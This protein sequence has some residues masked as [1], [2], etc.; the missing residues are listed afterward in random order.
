M[1][2]YKDETGLYIETEYFEKI[3][4]SFELKNLIKENKKRLWFYGW[5]KLPDIIKHYK[6]SDDWLY[7]KI[8]LWYYGFRSSIIEDRSKQYQTIN[9]PPMTRELYDE[10]KVAVEWLLKNPTGFGHFSTATGK[11]TMLCSLTSVLKKKTLIVCDA[12]SRLTQMQ[13]DIEEILWVKYQ[14]L[15][16]KKTK[17]NSKLSD[18]IVIANIDSIIK[19][20][21]FFIESFGTIIIDEADRMLQSDTRRNWVGSLSP[22]NLYGLTGTI[23]LNNVSDKI[24][25][26][27]FW[28]KTEYIIKHFIPTIHKVQTDFMFSDWQLEDM[29]EF[30]KLKQELY[31]DT[32]RNN[33]ITDVI[34]STINGRKAICFTEFIDHAKTLQAS[35]E[36]RGLKCFCIIGEVSGEDRET[37]RKQITEYPW[38][39]VLIW[40]K[41]CIGRG[42]NVP[43]L[44]VW[45]LTIC[46]KFTSSV[47]QYVW[48][49]IRKF[50]WKLQSNV[51]WYDFSDDNI[52]ILENQSKHR[53]TV[54]RREF[55]G[56]KF[57]QHF[58]G[59][60][61]YS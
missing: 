39:C 25:P 30:Y 48:R 43:E 4:S 44:S 20:P 29:K 7:V 35:L 9:F 46:E 45:Y 60:F 14:T 31:T 3:R 42:F 32:D 28:P 33:L 57:V 8:P 61:K 51:D 26:M 59:D 1:I 40:S 52:F 38:Q 37:I 53:N 2:W 47:E 49:I 12:I 54:Y 13:Q 22:N 58:S 18:D 34:V 15:S 41:V 24:F 21:R 27:Y 11:T 56:C 55:K 19:S 10:Q 23:S 36:K 6:R 16:G 5:H 17:A 50:E